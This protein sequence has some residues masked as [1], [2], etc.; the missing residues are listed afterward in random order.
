MVYLLRCYSYLSGLLSALQSTDD[1]AT[2]R[3][4]YQVEDLLHN[5]LD[6]IRITVVL[7]P[8]SFLTLHELSWLDILG[9]LHYYD[10][11]ARDA[12]IFPGLTLSG[13]SIYRG[14]K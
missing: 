9:S 11:Y 1:S 4:L 12:F 6:Q 5:Y 14:P 10:C 7:I 13:M 8:W 3:Y 2:L